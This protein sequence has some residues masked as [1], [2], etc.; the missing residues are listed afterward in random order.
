MTTAR[1]FI[2]LRTSTDDQHPENQLAD[3]LEYCKRLSLENPTALQE[4]GSAW[5]D[6]TKRPI[7]EELLKDCRN[8]KVD[9]VIVWDLDRL[10]RNRKKVVELIRGYSKLGVKFH[11]YRQAWLEQIQ[12][13]PEPWNEIIYDLLL[14]IVGWMGQEESMKRSDR[15]KIAY[16]R[17]ILTKKDWGRHA[18]PFTPEQVYALVMQHGSYRKAQ[19][20]LRYQ[21]KGKKHTRTVSLG[22][23]AELFKK[24]QAEMG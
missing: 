17:H 19:P 7:F 5:R 4:K 22:K 16:R 23:I 24:A 21:T 8:G 18:I 6:T 3:C 9:Q 11:S 13:V 20:F 14:N 2:Y 10:Y 12:G 1:V 15:V